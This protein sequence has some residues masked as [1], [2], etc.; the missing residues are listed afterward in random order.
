MS[1]MQLETFDVDFFCLIY[2]TLLPE[3]CPI[4]LKQSRLVI[5]LVKSSHIVFTREL[6]IPFLM[7]SEGCWQTHV[8]LPTGLTKPFRD[9][10]TKP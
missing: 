10:I 1:W 5:L 2:S 7:R 4:I 6:E 3:D 9:Y 8:E